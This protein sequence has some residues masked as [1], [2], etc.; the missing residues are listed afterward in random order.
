MVDEILGILG[1]S[2]ESLVLKIELK[3]KV[4]FVYQLAGT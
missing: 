2:I 1:I 3:H 4:V